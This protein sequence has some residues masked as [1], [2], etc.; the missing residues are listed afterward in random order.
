[1]SLP[2]HHAVD[3]F[4]LRRNRS[5]IIKIVLMLPLTWFCVFLYMNSPNKMIQ[6]QQQQGNPEQI[7]YVNGKLPVDG[8]PA[9]LVQNNVVD[10]NPIEV[11]LPPLKKNA[12]RKKKTT[13]LPGE[14]CS[15]NSSP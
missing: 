13:T 8:D 12:W 6:P 4:G 7:V 9:L 5:V 3:M 2:S 11:K 15:I 14:S 10:G 1:M